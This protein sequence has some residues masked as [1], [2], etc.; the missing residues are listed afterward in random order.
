MRKIVIGSLL[1]ALAC[2]GGSDIQTMP[3]GSSAEA[4]P[5][6]PGDMVRVAFSRE[7]DMNG[8]FLVDDRGMVALPLL[9]MRVVSQVPPARL[10]QE[11]QEAYEEQIR[12][13]TVQIVFL[14]RVRVLGAVSKPGLYQ[15]DPTMTIADVV[16]LAGGASANGKLNEAKI[17][18]DGHE[19]SARLDRPAV[20]QVH[21]GDQ[22]IIPQK[23]W[24]ARYSG[25]IIGT[26]L[27]LTA[28]II[29]QVTR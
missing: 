4:Q 1:A 27:S 22:I 14:R 15:A 21:S 7:K 18:R 8:D 13:E 5:L 16:A 29:R 3:S 9:E 25:L 12:N 19:Y 26:S 23:S 2:G 6:Q 28:I 10:R 11:L 20:E 24:A 17:L